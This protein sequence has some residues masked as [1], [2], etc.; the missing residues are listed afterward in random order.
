M[1]DTHAIE[2]IDLSRKFGDHVAVDQ[3]NLV[4]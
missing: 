1:T 2:A 4:V 3:V